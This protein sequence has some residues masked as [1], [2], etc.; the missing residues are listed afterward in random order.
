MLIL[1]V[2]LWSGF[3]RHMEISESFAQ[4]LVT[5]NNSS[6]HDLRDPSAEHF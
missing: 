3:K 4:A 2:G 6:S 5:V 1:D